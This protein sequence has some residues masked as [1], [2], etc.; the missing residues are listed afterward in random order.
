MPDSFARVKKV[1]DDGAMYRAVVDADYMHHAELVTALAAWA[2]KQPEPL[3]IVDLGCGDA[4]LATQAFA[5][6]NVASYHGVDVSDAASDVARNN[7]SIWPGRAQIIAGNL[8]DF[9]RS[10]PDGSANLVLASYSIHHFASDAKVKLI[11]HCRRVLTTAGT[12]IWID[13]VCRDGE[14]RRA[15]IDRLTHAMAN[16]WTALNTDQRERAC[17]HVRESDFPETRQWMLDLTA[18][19][20]FQRTE[21][22]LQRE[23][24]DGWIFIK[25]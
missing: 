20:G 7:V 21:T 18:A 8:A 3:R 2:H 6:A 23:F 17:T 15:Y 9:L 5:N 19:A 24:F 11:E 14:S 4:S 22:M 12:F 10:Q 16:D 1:F 13:A 25:S